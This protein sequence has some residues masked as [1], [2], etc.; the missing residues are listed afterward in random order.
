VIQWVHRSTR[1]WSYGNSVIDPRTGEILKGHVSLGSL[2]VRQDYLL[3]EGLLSPYADGSA[4]AP[5]SDP[6]LAMALARIR[7]LSAHEVGHTLGLSHN[8]A[9]SINNRASVMDYPAP[10]AEVNM[11]N[12]IVL[13]NA[14]DVGIG[15]WDKAAIRYG[16]AQ[17]PPGAD[18]GESLEAILSETQSSGLLYITDT[19][20]R[21]T[22]GAHPQAHLWDNDS[23]VLR[24]LEREMDVRHVALQ[25][26]SEN[27]IRTGRPI[28]TLEDVLV[29]LY[30][31]HRYQVEAASKLVGGVRYLY[32]VRGDDAPPPEPVDGG[33]QRR[34]LEAL[35][36]TVEPS[37]LHLPS[38]TRS[39]IPPRP[40][41]YG[42]S[43]ELFDGYSGLTFDA[44]AP[45]EVAAHLVL[46]L[47]IHPERAARL[48]YQHLENSNLPGLV[49]VLNTITRRV[50][51]GPIPSNAPEAE[52]QRIVQHVWTALLVER[53]ADRNAAPHVRATATEH[54]HVLQGWLESNEGSDPLTRA[55]RHL[56]EAEI[57]RFLFRIYDP[58]SKPSFVDTPPG[59]PIGSGV[60]PLADDVRRRRVAINRW[61]AETE[62]CGFVY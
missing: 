4:P 48:G 26:F 8:F 12:E 17:F 36:E 7:Q 25:K 20:A 15:E 13:D 39:S 47:L 2:R 28:A 45:A 19:D 61:L 43:S 22:G 9:S 10:L 27:A 11:N 59:S 58:Q 34:A 55:H 46:S 51:E 41:G 30:L 21:P 3:A 5:E 44:Y 6:M 23:D 56:L 50:W 40:P 18:E 52:T 33:T 37:V 60:S 54:L 29:P 38:S 14:Y 16:Y 62:L 35:L 57:E 53:A 32:A 42:D 49:E 1:G 31:R 24:A